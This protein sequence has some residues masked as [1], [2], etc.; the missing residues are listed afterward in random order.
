MSALTWSSLQTVLQAI[1]ARIPAP[2]TATDAGF[3]ELYPQATSYAEHR[4]YNDMPALA[5]RAQDISLTTTAGSR[6]INLYGTALPVIVPQR[7][8]LLTPSGSTL[9]NGTQIPFLPTSLDFIDLYWPQESLEGAPAS[10]LAN[11]WCNLGGVSGSDF[12]S[13]TVIIAP[14][15]DAAY[16]VVLTGLFTQAPIS[17]SNP[18][19]YL[20]TNYP[21]VLT[22]ACMVYISG[23]L[24]RNYSSAGNPAQPDDPGMPVHWEGQYRVLLEAAKAEEARRRGLGTDYLDRLPAPSGPPG[25]AA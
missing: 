20:S 23:A 12:T 3:Q 17:A 6:T 15:P 8:A 7:L 19:T 25:R 9:A 10:S 4:I 1:I 22:A 16:K 14:T 13:P 5:Q 2:W 21:E 18:Q 11:Y 24:L